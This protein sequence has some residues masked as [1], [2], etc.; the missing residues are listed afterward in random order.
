MQTRE[1]RSLH[2]LCKLDFEAGHFTLNLIYRRTERWTNGG[3]V[4]VSLVPSN[5]SGP[6]VTDWIEDSAFSS[7]RT[8]G[9]ARQIYPL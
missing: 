8:C 2:G 3:K 4:L 1:S 6:P 5:T 9:L 7:N